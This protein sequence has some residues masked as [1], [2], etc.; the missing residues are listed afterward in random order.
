MWG[1]VSNSLVQYLKL[2][3]LIPDDWGG[4]SE[5][6]KVSREQSSR[7]THFHT[8]HNTLTKEV[9]HLFLPKVCWCLWKHIPSVLLSLV[10]EPPF[11]NFYNL[12]HLIKTSKDKNYTLREEVSPFAFNLLLADAHVLSRLNSH[13]LLSIL[14]F[15]VS[16][17][18]LPL[19][20]FLM[21]FSL[22][23]IQYRVSCFGKQFVFEEINVFL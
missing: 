5:L 7:L 13:Y 21:A 20:R 2:Q 17:S 14:P 16:I 18:F 1:R 19:S 11:M 6:F 10:F 4:L 3:W 12:H 22:P 8:K 9:M 15:M 23:K